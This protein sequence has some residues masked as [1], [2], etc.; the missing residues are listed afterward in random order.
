MKRPDSKKIDFVRKNRDKYSRNL[1]AKEMGI[2]KRELLNILKY[3]DEYPQGLPEKEKFDFSFSQKWIKLIP[4]FIFLASFILRITYFLKAQHDPLINIPILDAAY[5]DTWARKILEGV[6]INNAF[7]AEPGYAYLIWFFYKIFGVGKIYPIIWL[8]MIFSS[9]TPVVIYFIVKRITANKLASI[10]GAFLGIFL[11]PLLF[12]DLL[13]LKTSIEILLISA[14]SLLAIVAFEK[15]RIRYLFILGLLIG[16]TALVKAN[17]L[18]AFPFLSA[19]LFFEERPFFSKEKLRL[20]AAGCLGIIIFV[21][22]VAAR[23]FVV[24]RSLVLINY[25]SGPNLYIGNWEGADGTLK[26]PEYIS[27]DP[28]TEETSWRKMADSY[29]QRNLNSSEI[30]S[31]WTNKA[32]LEAISQPKQEISLTL[33]KLFLVFSLSS[34][35]DNYDIAYGKNIFPFLSF[36]IPFWFL[37]I[38]G[39]TGMAAGILEKEKK[40]Y[41]LFG[42]FLGYIIILIA[43]HILERYRLA[44][45]P[46]LLVFSGYFVYWIIQKISEQEQGKI[47][48]F[49]TAFFIVLSLTAIPVNNITKTNLG[50]TYSNLAE[51]FEESGD[52]KAAEKYYLMAIQAD[53]NNPMPKSGLAKIF[54]EEG[55]YDE[56]IDYYREAIRIKYDM[57]T[58]ELKLAMDAKGGNINS[59]DVR[60]K[61]DEE[62]GKQ[63]TEIKSADFFDGLAFFRKQKYDDAIPFFERVYAEDPESEAVL[64]N[65]ATSYKNTKQ[66]DKAEQFFKKA[67]AVNPYSLVAMFNLGNLYSQKKSYQQAADNYEKINEIVPG[68]NL[69]RYY[70]G[71]TYLDLKD[72]LRALSTLNKFLEESEGNKD[73]EG[74]RQKAQ[75][76]VSGIK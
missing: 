37:A 38:F 46:F 43:T 16:L 42:L 72:K 48:F 4:F 27:V 45:A 21:I 22:P 39:I 35:D 1:L 29:S 3:L 70:L 18:Y 59:E 40:L 67:L 23:N 68:Y 11:Q 52:K 73:L 60:K 61:L 69:S 24:D 30:S 55:K 56:A 17:I 28:K 62:K 32:L 64:T 51:K 15:K 41:P 5:Y 10:A 65:L 19:V 74:V 47:T 13:L 8:Q 34:A 7:F 75:Q 57:P 50:D 58:T 2:S 12:Y 31:F 63:E 33:K 36:L 71:L 6:K 20:F 44:L 26:P 54:L 25:S 76:I 53:P 66:E 9:L 14:V 49:L